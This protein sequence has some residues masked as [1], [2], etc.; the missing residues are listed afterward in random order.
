MDFD[1]YVARINELAA[2]DGGP[3][4]YCDAAAWRDSFDDGMTPA[5]AW[6]SEKSYWCE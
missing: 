1:Q 5:E 6:A 2:A 3:S 4:P